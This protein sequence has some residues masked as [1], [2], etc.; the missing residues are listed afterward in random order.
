MKHLRNF[1]CASLSAALLTACG[2]GNHGFSPSPPMVAP[3]IGASVATQPNKIIAIGSGFSSPHDVAVGKY[4]YAYVADTGHHAI[5]K[6]AP[7]GTI[8][9][10]ASLTGSQG[11]GGDAIDSVGSVYFTDYY[12]SIHG[13]YGA[14]YKITADKKIVAVR[15]GFSIPWGVVV[16]KDGYSYVA[17]V[18]S[19]YLYTISPNGKHLKKVCT[20]FFQ[21]PND[22]AVDAAGNVYVA[23]WGFSGTQYHGAV[24]MI[25]PSQFGSCAALTR[26]G[27]GFLHPDGVAV[28][29]AGNVYVSDLGHNAVKKVAP[30]GTITQVG[31]G[32]WHPGGVAVDAAGNVFVADTG[33]NAVKEVTR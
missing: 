27:S 28:D 21:Q 8:T 10:I 24:Y 22:V 32:F 12:A 13:P 4:G 14:V 29:A 9:T 7:N 2:G 26:I 25:R 5:K 19:G 15:S 1:V 16:D 17:D 6:V 30:D 33:H 3:P 11:P 20:G 23:V 31:S 18:R